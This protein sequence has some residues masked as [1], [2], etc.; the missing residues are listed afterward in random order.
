MKVLKLGAVLVSTL[1]V[2]FAAGCGD[3]SGESGGDGGS[4]D[5]KE[6]IVIGAV[7]GWTGFMNAFDVPPYRAME[8]AVEDINKEGGVLG[9]PLK[10]INADGKSDKVQAGTAAIGLLDKGADVIAAPCDFDFGAAAAIEAQK[11]D[12]VGISYCAGTVQFGV[13]GIG[14]NA[15][16]MATSNAGFMAALGEWAYEE[17]GLRNAYILQDNAT[18]YHKQGCRAFKAKWETLDGAKVVGYDFFQNDDPSIAA[19]ITR[20]KGA[21]DLDFVALCSVAPG[22]V[23]ALRQIR[24]AGIDVPILG[25]GLS[26]DGE[27][28]KKS[29]PKL[30]NFYTASYAS[31]GGDDP[32]PRVNELIERL[33]SKFGDEPVEGS[34]AFTAGYSMVEA[35]KIAAEKA[36]SVEGPELVKALDSFKDEDLLVG[37]TTF[38]PELHINLTREA[39]L[40]EIQNGKTTFMKHWTPKSVPPTDEWATG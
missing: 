18:E 29:V 26:F 5:S 15:Y 13:Q 22:G 12:K 1:L 32:D 30:S 4:G 21:K 31:I 3:D 33:R 14:P 34:S 35:I 39:A 36:G 27:Y 38:T 40:L 28:W 24:S 10:L 19:Q 16:T 8:L 9:R 25:E 23:T 11:R 6:P 7:V 20:L 37:P 2:A 17:K